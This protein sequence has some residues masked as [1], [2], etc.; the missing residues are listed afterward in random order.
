MKI[1]SHLLLP[2]LLMTAFAGCSDDDDSAP[3]G[4]ASGMISGKIQLTDEFGNDVVDYSGMKVITQTG[5][6]GFSDASGEFTIMNLKSGTYTLNYE[7]SG[8]GTYRR[9]NIVVA[10]TSSVTTLNGTDVL[11]QKSSTLITNLTASW[12]PIDQTFTFGCDINPV[13]DPVNARNFRL[14]FNKTADVGY[15]NYLF[16]PNNSW[17][18]TTGTGII[19]GFSPQTLLSN[20]FLP[21][22]SVY[23]VALGESA[24]SN[25]YTNPVTGK[26]LYPNLN[27]AGPS[28]VAGFK[29]P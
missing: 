22:D 26:K 7:K 25:S 13:P 23:V 3:N 18:A 12:E 9:F 6:F 24:F 8:Y 17:T 21:G 2:V 27:T 14:F 29:I 10:G 4:N 20:G 11:A 16:T 15:D 28:N 5:A 1:I 19:T